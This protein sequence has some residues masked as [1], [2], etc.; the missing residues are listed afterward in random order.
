MWAV[1]SNYRKDKVCECH[2]L[3]VRP[4]HAVNTPAC[5]ATSKPQR[6]LLS[7]KR[8]LPHPDFMQSDWQWYWLRCCCPQGSHVSVSCTVSVGSVSVAP[9]SSQSIVHGDFVTFLSHQSKLAWADMLMCCCVSSVWIYLLSLWE[10]KWSLPAW[11]TFTASH[12]A[13][14]LF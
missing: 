11:H 3:C 8:I 5:E 12:W 10:Q 1:I 7:L 6:T 9:E 14:K 2:V 4:H 13:F